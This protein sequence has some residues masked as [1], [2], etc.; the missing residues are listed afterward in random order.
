LAY[1]ASADVNNNSIGSQNK[2][3]PSSTV[4]SASIAYLNNANW[5]NVVIQYNKSTTNTWTITTNGV[6]VVNNDYS[7]NAGWVSGASTYWG[8]GSS[9]Y[10]TSGGSMNT[11]IRNVRLTRT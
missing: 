2:V 10:T 11:Y 9:N 6:T 1:T 4:Y 8:I 3:Q 5:T 7:G